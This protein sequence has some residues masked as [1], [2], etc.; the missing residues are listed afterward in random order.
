MNSRTLFLPLAC[1]AGSLGAEGGVGTLKPANELLRQEK[2]EAAAA[3]YE[4]MGD[5]VKAGDTFRRA[6][7]ILSVENAALASGKKAKDPEAA[8]NVAAGSSITAETLDEQP[9]KL[10]GEALTAALKEANALM[11]AGN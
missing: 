2:Y 4:K 7:E 10:K 1:L 8:Q 5:R 3:A 11:D 9:T 6:M